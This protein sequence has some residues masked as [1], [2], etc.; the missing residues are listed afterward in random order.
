MLPAPERNRAG[1]SSDRT[2]L[3]KSLR[4][5]V[6]L[7]FVS[8]LSPIYLFAVIA[9]VQQHAKNNSLSMIAPAV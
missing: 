2:C 8:A 6:R 3:E 9:S 1:S 5:I 4:F 7:F